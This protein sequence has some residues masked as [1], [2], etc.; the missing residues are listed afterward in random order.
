[1]SC[2]RYSLVTFS[3]PQQILQIR[4]PLA[5]QTQ[6]PEQLVLLLQHLLEFLSFWSGLSQYALL[7]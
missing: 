1:M 3:R 7:I 5:L 4:F 2:I 6:S